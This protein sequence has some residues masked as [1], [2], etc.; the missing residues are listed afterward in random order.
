M[1]CN[2][3]TLSITSFVITFARA[4]QGHNNFYED[5]LKAFAIENSLFLSTDGFENSPSDITV[6]NVTAFIQY[7]T[8]KEEREVANHIKKLHFWGKIAAVLFLD[9]GHGKLLKILMSELKLFNK[10]LTG[11]I[12]ESDVFPELSW[13]LRFDTFLF[14]YSTSVSTI[15]L[16]EIYGVNGKTIVTQIGTHKEGSG[17]SISATNMWDRRTDMEGMEIRV[18]TLSYPFLHELY[19]DKLNTSV[20]GGG[21]LFIEPLNILAQKLN[22]SM[23]FMSSIDGQWGAMNQNGTWTGLI[24]MLI[25]GQA[26]IAAAGL[27]LTFERTEVT[28]FGIGFELE[29][30]TLMSPQT[31]EREVHLDVYLHIFPGP[32]WCLIGA[33]VI[34][35]GTCFATINYFGIN[36]MHDTND[37][38]EFT[39][40]NGIGLSLT[41]FRQIYYNVKIESISS[42]TL[43]IISTM[44]T[45]LLYVHYSAYMTATTTT[46]IKE[47][48]VKSFKDVLSGGY[49]V[50]VAKNT[51]DHGILKSAKPGTPMHDVYY[52][53]MDDNPDAFLNSYKE[54]SRIVHTEKALSFG[55][56][57]YMAVL[58]DLTVLDI[59]VQTYIHLYFTFVWLC[60]HIVNMQT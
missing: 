23:K 2:G 55:S 30:F 59:Q 27:S 7:T 46:G 8:N 1:F 13:E 49:Q 31:T 52:K 21:G 6:N 40:I 12:P 50:F 26:D 24:G 20:I 48:P 43:F 42:R 32:V 33:M 41:F 44:S 4:T 16:K 37:S 35:F 19:Y 22:F 57:Y 17:L 60:T 53:T 45:Y 11:L 34:S 15:H 54:V 18:A 36:Y 56:A 14:V 39:L 5:F 29:E 3:L 38:E 9:N 28:T 47:S 58:H 10:G 25:R 51:A